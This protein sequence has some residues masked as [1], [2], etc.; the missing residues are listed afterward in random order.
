MEMGVVGTFDQ[1]IHS[2]NDS[3]SDNSKLMLMLNNNTN[4]VLIRI[5]LPWPRLNHNL[6]LGLVIALHHCPHLSKPDPEQGH[7]DRTLLLLCKAW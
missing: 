2:H 1:T 3:I 6:P 5:I 7:R 4:W